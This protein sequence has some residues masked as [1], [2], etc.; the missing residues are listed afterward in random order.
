MGW[1][2]AQ[3]VLMCIFFVPGAYFTSEYVKIKSK[4]EALEVATRLPA[5]RLSPLSYLT[6]DEVL[7]V[8]TV[9]LPSKVSEILLTNKK[10]LK[11]Y[12]FSRK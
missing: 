9:F 6:A 4:I 2:G 3:V 10:L 8:G 5:Q 12:N 7:N 1:S 11:F